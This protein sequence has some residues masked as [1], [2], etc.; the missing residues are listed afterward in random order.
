MPIVVQF[1]KNMT[2][3]TMEMAATAASPYRPAIWFRTM[4]ETAFRLC[5]VRD[6][7]PFMMICRM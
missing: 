7:K 3:F 6:G 4:V 1:R 5:R 2:R